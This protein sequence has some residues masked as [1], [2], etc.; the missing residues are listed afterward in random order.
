[1]ERICLII[2]LFILTSCAS[3]LIK[4]KRH[5]D[6]IKELMLKHPELADSLELVHRDTLRSEG[7]KDKTIAVNDS[8][9][10]DEDFF[11][12][13]DTSAWEIIRADDGKKAAPV[14]KLQTKICPAID[15]DSTYHVRVY[16]SKLTLWVPI[17]LAVKAKNG[18]ITID[19]M[20]DN[21]KIPEPT[22]TKTLEFR[23]VKPKFYADQ[24]FWLF[25]LLVAILVFLLTQQL[26]QRRQ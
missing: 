20:S 13:V 19:I 1:M 25:I 17:H 21:I 24:W 4:A 22:V 18:K 6:A 16:N 11:A 5:W 12:S 10:W 3:P 9:V 15:K 23:S 26:R 14:T 2:V 7:F 8:S